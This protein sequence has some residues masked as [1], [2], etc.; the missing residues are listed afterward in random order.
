M[1]VVLLILEILKLSGYIVLAIMS[2]LKSG[3]SI[4]NCIKGAL[5]WSLY[6]FFESKLYLELN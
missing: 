2:S 6:F 4:K 1:N 5:F 3:V